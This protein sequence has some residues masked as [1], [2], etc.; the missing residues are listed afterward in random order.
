MNHPSLLPT[1]GVPFPLHMRSNHQVPYYWRSFG[2]MTELS[3]HDPPASAGV[4]EDIKVVFRRLI[5]RLDFYWITY[6]NQIDKG[7][8]C[9]MYT[10][11]RDSGLDGLEI[12]PLFSRSF[13][14]NP[15]RTV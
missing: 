10:E 4:R 14:R 15:H 7:Y 12:Q 2:N 3:T 8:D 9:A 13:G 11:P 6:R 5:S 1:I